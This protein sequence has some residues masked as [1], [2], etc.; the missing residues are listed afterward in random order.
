MLVLLPLASFRDCIIFF[1]IT[2]NQEQSYQIKKNVLR[3]LIWW[4]C[5]LSLS[6]N[7]I[8]LCWNKIQECS[9][10]IIY[11]S[12]IIKKQLCYFKMR[13]IVFL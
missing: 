12:L 10:T 2:R 5:S 11:I 8:N 3:F 4:S 6:E 7:S 13:V 1:L 9:V